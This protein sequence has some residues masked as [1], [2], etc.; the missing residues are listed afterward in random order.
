MG[1]HWT[2]T[3]DENSIPFS[4]MAVEIREITL[5]TYLLDAC[6][7]TFCLAV[8]SWILI[9]EIWNRRSK[10]VDFKAPALKWFS[11]LTLLTNVLFLSHCLLNWFPYICYF[12]ETARH[13]VGIFLLLSLGLYQLSRLYYTFANKKVLKSYPRWLFVVMISMAVII[14]VMNQ[15]VSNSITMH[16]GWEKQSGSLQSLVM[17]HELWRI[18]DYRMMYI[19]WV[20]NFLL[21]IAWD[22][23]TLMLFVWKLRSLPIPETIA[24]DPVLVK[25][26]RNITRIIILTIFYEIPFLISILS[27][28]VIRVILKLDHSIKWTVFVEYFLDRTLSI[29]MA[30]S[31]YFMLQHNSKEYG[32]FLTW[33]VKFK[34]QFCCCCYHRSVIKQRDYF[35]ALDSTASV[36]DVDLQ[37]TS[38]VDTATVFNEFSMDD[39]PTRVQS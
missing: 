15:I 34:L 16:C 11:I 39:P 9:K 24:S 22:L 8:A 21:Y 29:F 35:T 17:V 27:A 13:L 28:I 6:S 38:K 12:N 18:F 19:L 25:I 31:V 3:K 37:V 20:I 4:L 5:S 2:N 32:I 7:T 14:L 30:L 23:T 36:G 26:R 1:L 10:D 33:I